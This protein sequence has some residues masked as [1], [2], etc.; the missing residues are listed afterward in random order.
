MT[1]SGVVNQ[2][3]SA[4]SVSLTVDK[5]EIKARFDKYWNEVKDIL[6]QNLVQSALKGGFRKVTRQR[7]VKVAG[8]RGAF[9]APA[10]GDLITDYL[11]TQD[12]QALAI[13][14]VD[15]VEDEKSETVNVTAS[16]YLEPMIT[17]KKKLGIDEPLKVKMYK[18]PENLVEMLVEQE[19]KNKQGQSVVLEPLGDEVKIE[20]GN[21]AI[22]DGQSD[23]VK[24]DGTLVKWEPGC[25]TM[26]KWLIDESTVKSPEIVQ[27]LIG[28]AKGEVR[29]IEFVLNDKFG[30][31]V[32]KKIRATL[33]VQGVF[34][35]N[36]PAIDDDL[37]KTNGYDSLSIYKQALTSGI[38][39]QL[40]KE[41]EMLQKQSIIATLANEEVVAVEPLPIEWLRAKGQERYY[42]GRK[43]VKTEE[44]LV[45]QFNGTKLFNGTPVTDRGTVIRFLAERAAKELIEDLIIRSWGK[46]KGVAGNSTLKNLGNYNEAVSAEILKVVVF[47]EVEVPK[48]ATV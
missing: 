19:L 22:L 6:P 38:T 26:N 47:E 7:I 2:Q 8:G 4:F 40:I 24:E 29:A 31:D 23:E 14:G 28:A 30:P 27:V 37:A 34:K 41:R 20:T 15:M 35:C 5:A 18:E 1:I 33:K 43:A 9:Y 13:N 10:L 3:A 36:M 11:D 25:F 32:G 16:V 45:A 39:K 42:E 17:W 21:V 44:E 12:R 48:N 46:L